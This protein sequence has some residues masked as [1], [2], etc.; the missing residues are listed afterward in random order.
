MK[1]QWLH[2]TGWVALFVA[3]IVAL[4]FVRAERA[5]ETCWRVDVEVHTPGQHGFLTEGMVRERLGLLGDSLQGMPM[6][7]IDIQ[8]LQTA[9]DQMAFVRECQV[10]KTL[11]GR[12][13]IQADSR[14]P[15]VR[16]VQPDGTGF[17]LD[18]DRRIMPVSNRYSAHLPLVVSALPIDVHHADAVDPTTEKVRPEG[19]L[20]AIVQSV[21]AVEAH[22]LMR[23][24]CEH[25][26]LDSV[27]HFS[28]VPRVGD[29]VIRLG[30]ARDLRQK[31]DRLE[32]F[33]KQTIQQTDLNAY[34]EINLAYRDQ[35][36]CK[37]R[38]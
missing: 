5:T 29:Y 17:Y 16:V 14:E 8:R 3:G 18:T 15:F 34:T 37:R 28:A 27:G 6:A 22:S 9:V 30:A 36:V 12:V 2:I 19:P 38:W 26:Y 1:K 35:V 4:G 21:E 24:L 20:G 33:L 25:L 11:D 7:A 23:D 32:A 13:I 10:T 31:F